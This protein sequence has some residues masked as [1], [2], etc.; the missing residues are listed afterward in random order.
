M[1]AW[2]AQWVQWEH[3]RIHLY[4]VRRVSETEMQLL[5]Q[6]QPYTLISSVNM[7]Y[8]DK[9]GGG[10]WTRQDVEEE[11]SGKGT[12]EDRKEHRGGK[13]A[14]ELKKRSGFKS[15]VRRLSLLR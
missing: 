6:G 8:T 12:G 14:K 9:S 13:Q 2:P 1:G 3:S 4:E 7:V 11:S 10:K 15:I 5:R